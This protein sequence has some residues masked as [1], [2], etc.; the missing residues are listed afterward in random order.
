MELSGLDTFAPII[1]LLAGINFAYI[2]TSGIS[3]VKKGLSEKSRKKVDCLCEGV[4]SELDVELQSL[5][6]IK[7]NPLKLENGK[8]NEGRITELIN[9]AH[10]IKDSLNTT[11]ESF[12]AKYNEEDS[13]SL[14]ILFL[15]VGL[16]CIIAL[17][18]IGLCSK[19][20]VGTAC[21]SIYMLYFWL[22]N[23]IVPSL[24]IV[25]FFIPCEK[26]KYHSSGFAFFIL[27]LLL[28]IIPVSCNWMTQMYCENLNALITIVFPF[29]AIVVAFYKVFFMDLYIIWYRLKREINSIK[30]KIDILKNDVTKLKDSIESFTDPNVDEIEIG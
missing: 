8:T 20:R 24:S 21:S 22:L 27:I 30:K 6:T 9:K 26:L 16:Y 1:Q 3:D 15:H 25:Y 23:W 2:I 4:V 10:Q 28:L 29:I 12:K 14:S 17:I 11:K 19:T 5:E 18:M 13:N 7:K